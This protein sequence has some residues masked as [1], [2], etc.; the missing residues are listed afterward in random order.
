MVADRAADEWGVLSLAE[1]RACG[2]SPKAVAIRVRNGWLHPLH[3]GVYA[4][5]HRAVTLEG[6]LLAAVKSVGADA[7]LSYF[8]AAARWVSST[9]MGAIQT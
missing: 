3:R 8:A 7:E 1:L 2:L 4:V 5:G 6:R 9:G